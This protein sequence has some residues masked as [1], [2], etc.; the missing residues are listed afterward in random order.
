LILLKL[1]IFYLLTPKVYS[2]L[3]TPTPYEIINK[4]IYIRGT[5]R[6]VPERLGFFSIDKEGN[7]ENSTSISECSR[8]L[9]LGRRTIKNC[10]L[11]GIIKVINLFIIN[12]IFYVLLK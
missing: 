8:A 11:L 12:S 10:L 7:Q 6:L 3:C 4:I 5:D 2:I 9:N 1:I